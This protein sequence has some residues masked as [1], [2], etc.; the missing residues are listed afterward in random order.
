MRGKSQIQAFKN[1]K[2]KSF[3]KE[4]VCK[5]Q[6]LDS[7]LK[8]RSPVTFLSDLRSSLQCNEPGSRYNIPLIN[9]LVLYVGTQA[10][11][12][13]H[14]KG[15]NPSMSTIAHSSHMDIFQNLAVDMDTEGKIYW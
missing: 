13:I 10:I 12:H 2:K 7:Y 6:D 14:T 5:L 9:A 3:D 4:F 15:L 11:Q 1:N 8:T